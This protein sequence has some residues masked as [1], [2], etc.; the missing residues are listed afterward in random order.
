MFKHVGLLMGVLIIAAM[1]GGVVHANGFGTI[2]IKPGSDPNSIDP[3]SRGVIPVAILSTAD[4][5]AATVDPSTLVFGPY[6]TNLTP[7]TGATPIHKAGGH[8]EDVN[9]DGLLDLLSHYLTKETTIASGDTVACVTA[10]L[11]DGTPF[12]GCDAIRTVPQ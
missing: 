4:F 12:E 8:L 3:L 11:I 7:K 5:D 10:T 1:V 6:V 2:D 9:N